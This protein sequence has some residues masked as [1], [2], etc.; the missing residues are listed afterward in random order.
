MIKG[1]DRAINCIQNLIPESDNPTAVSREKKAYFR[2]SRSYKKILWWC[3]TLKL[4]LH[5]FLSGVY[6]LKWLAVLFRVLFTT[7]ANEVY[8]IDSGISVL[9]CL[10]KLLLVKIWKKKKI[11]FVSKNFT[12]T[13]KPQN[14]HL[15][16]LN[17]CF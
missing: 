13:D 10:S 7:L 12:A 17:D 16:G 6:E 15:T 4:C 11:F 5:D 2:S 14:C 9:I 3:W 8:L 1:R